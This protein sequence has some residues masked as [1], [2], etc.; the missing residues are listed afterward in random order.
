MQFKTGHAVIFPLSDNLLRQVAGVLA[1]H[2]EIAKLE[3]QGHTDSRGGKGYNRKL[4][5]KTCRL[6]AE[7]AGELRPGRKRPPRLTGTAWKSHCGQRHA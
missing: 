4:S 1:E 6:R 7:V 5:Q 3:V 2:P